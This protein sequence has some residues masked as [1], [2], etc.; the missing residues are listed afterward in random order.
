M[1]KLEKKAT[2]RKRK[3]VLVTLD[4]DVC[5]QIREWSLQNGFSQFDGHTG[6]TRGLLSRGLEILAMRSLKRE[7]EEQAVA[8]QKFK[9]S[10][11]T[12]TDF[13]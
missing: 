12:D 6:D 1:E 11:L 4:P 2:G 7:K 8:Q 3:S 5:R 13:F 10:L 9:P